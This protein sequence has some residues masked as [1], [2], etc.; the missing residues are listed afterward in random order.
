MNTR[1]TINVTVSTFI[2]GLKTRQ[3]TIYKKKNITVI[4]LLLSLKNIK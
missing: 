3:P 2:D 1:T 4:P